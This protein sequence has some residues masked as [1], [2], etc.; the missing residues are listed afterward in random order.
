MTKQEEL[1]KG[2]FV[3]VQWVDIV[4]DSS[5]QEFR[6]PEDDEH[7]VHDCTSF[8][9]ITRNNKKYITLSATKGV[10]GTTEYNQSINIPW[11]VVSQVDEIT[12]NE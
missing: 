4:A 12:I 3:R 11:G 2:M 8:G 5:W 7:A 1:K 10:N 9:F 6:E